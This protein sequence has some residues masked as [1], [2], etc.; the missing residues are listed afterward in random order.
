MAAALAQVERESKSDPGR[1][2]MRIKKGN[3]AYGDL[4]YVVS[5]FV[6]IHFL[7]EKVNTSLG[8]NCLQRLFLGSST[9]STF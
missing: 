5:I 8:Y 2:M 9:V 1:L 6:R 3:M 7:P 4:K